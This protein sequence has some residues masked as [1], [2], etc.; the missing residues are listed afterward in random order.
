MHSWSLKLRRL[1]LLAAVAAAVAACGRDD[2]PTPA[3]DG[4][5]A[6]AAAA[7]EA[8]PTEVVFAFIQEGDTVAIERFTRSDTLLQGEIRDIN[9][10][11]RARYEARID[12]GGRIRR[13]ETIFFDTA[14]ATEPAGRLVLAF[15]GDT[16]L[17]EQ[18]EGDEVT[19]DRA[20]LPPGTMLYMNPS[21]GL[22]EQLLARARTLGGE[23][24]EFPLLS[25]GIDGSP[26]LVRPSI[27]WAGRD[28]VH[29]AIEQEG[30]A[31][32]AV[33]AGTRILGGSGAHGDSRIARI[34]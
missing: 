5:G 31:R 7:G 12:T 9:S 3:A 26:R 30:Y 34:R 29:V 33:E 10:G 32:F 24:V 11:A 16:L 6:D 18:H 8:Q 25:L 20:E 1:A 15:A 23:N 28:S 14:G 22:M 27:R 2:S 13:L 4:T 21:I 17:V 19:E